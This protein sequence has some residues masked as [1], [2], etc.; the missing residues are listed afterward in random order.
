V[1]V[2]ALVTDTLNWNRHTR[3]LAREAT[4]SVSEILVADGGFV[5]SFVAYKR[6]A[7]QVE[8][9]EEM[10]NLT[11]L[12]L[13]TRGYLALHTSA[14]GEYIVSITINRP[15]TVAEAKNAVEEAMTGKLS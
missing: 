3:R 8:V 1:Q 10:P 7:K 11:A 14:E 13:A 4:H 5:R 6:F 9:M 15:A 12:A 2:E